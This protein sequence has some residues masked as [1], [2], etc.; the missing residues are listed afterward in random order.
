MMY[1]LKAFCN[2]R[3]VGEG[4]F[5]EMFDALAEANN[6]MHLASYPIDVDEFEITTEYKKREI[7]VAYGFD[8]DRAIELQK[9]DEIVSLGEAK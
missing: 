4:E 9:Q 3:V 2:G 7:I 5:V 1:K 6:A 8:D